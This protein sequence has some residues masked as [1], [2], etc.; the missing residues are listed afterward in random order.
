M[1]FCNLFMGRPSY[2]RNWCKTGNEALTYL[3]V[4]K[5]AALVHVHLRA[6][7]SGA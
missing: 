2:I 3:G 6:R 7:K 1:P 4:A 5:D